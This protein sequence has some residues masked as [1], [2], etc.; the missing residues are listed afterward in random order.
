MGEA[1]Y[2]EVCMGPLADEIWM[3]EEHAGCGGRQVYAVTS[4]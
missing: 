4:A 1:G 3:A 2:I